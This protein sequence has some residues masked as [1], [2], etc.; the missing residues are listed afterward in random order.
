MAGYLTYQQM[1]DVLDDMAAKFPNLITVKA[2]VSDTNLTW[3]GRPLWYVKISDNPNTDEPEK[4]V[5]YTALHHA[6]EPNSLSQMIFYMWYL[7]ENYDTNPEIQY[8]VNNL[9]LYFI[10]CVKPA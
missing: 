6:R 1:L 3:E 9:D 8:L 5:L 2:V 10:P 4:E 7:L